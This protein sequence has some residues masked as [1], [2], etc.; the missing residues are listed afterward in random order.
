M[1][2]KQRRHCYNVHDVTA[3]YA[4]RMLPCVSHPFR[5]VAVTMEA[6]IWRVHLA[7]LPNLL[8]KAG[9]GSWLSALS[10]FRQ[11]QQCRFL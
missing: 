2:G 8:Q 4:D 5:L 3:N 6:Q 9:L 7:V 11:L 10:L 1:Q